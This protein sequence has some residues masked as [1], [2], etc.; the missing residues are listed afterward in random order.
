MDKSGLMSPSEAHAEVEGDGKALEEGELAENEASPKENEGVAEGEGEGEESSTATGVGA[1][2]LSVHLNV[3]VSADA[4]A[5]T[6][7]AS[8]PSQQLAPTSYNKTRSFFDNLKQSDK[9][10]KD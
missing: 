3:N 9:Y 7:G 6:A 10:D 1:V 2:N 5:L 8:T 4:G